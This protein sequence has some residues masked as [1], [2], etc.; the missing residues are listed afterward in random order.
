MF[1]KN[2]LFA[3]VV[4]VWLTIATKAGITWAGTYTE[5]SVTFI[6]K[7]PVLKWKIDTSSSAYGTYNDTLATTG[8]GVLDI[9]A[10]YGEIPADDMKAM[11]AA[12]FLEGAL[13]AER[14]YQN[15][16]NMHAFYF[17]GE[18]Q[19]L[20]P[21]V[22][23][24]FDEQE[25][26]TR[27]MIAKN[28]NDQFWRSIALIV[29]QL[30]GLVD[31]YSNNPY[32]NKSLERFAFQMLNSVGDL[33]DLRHALSPS[34]RPDWSKMNPVE[35][36]SYFMRHGH[37]SALIK[38]LGAYEN[39][40]M[41]HSSWFV[42]ASTSRIYKH[43]NFNLKSV[44]VASKQMS[45]SSYPGFLESLDDFYLLGN[46]LVMLQTTLN[47]FNNSLYDY[48]V[49]QS[50]LAW[51]RV[52]AA[53]MLAHN[54]KEWS[55]ILAKYNSGTYNN[56]YMIIDLNLIHLNESI[57]DNALWVVEQMPT[58]VKSGDQSPILRA[59]YFPSYNVPFYEEVFNISG[60]PEM[61]AKYGTDYS[62]QLAP[63]AKIFRRDQG[64]VKSFQD[65]KHLMRYNDYLHD[66]YSQMDPCK[67]ICCRG[68]LYKENPSADGC[69]DTKLS[70]YHMARK[71]QSEAISGPTLGTGLPPFEWTPKFPDMHVGLPQIYNFSFLT[72]EPQL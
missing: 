67:A 2:L 9:K 29:A 39:I 21:K 8:W 49:P 18:K 1:V 70:D 55:Q 14:I 11:Y 57:D 68:D 17:G 50:L 33:I 12:G 25:T 20:E 24:F 27:S 69:Y 53:N 41:S 10:G 16:L 4:V 47:V 45:F 43:Y 23:K 64:K 40:F 31:G 62:Y 65:M 56:E 72:M 48:V 28:P 52:R 26:W 63:R 30:D 13:T 36:Q 58:M 34:T 15:Y 35:F 61:V 5:G 51:Y 60:Y 32:Q 71:L 59:G 37:C 6:G 46:G 44:D 3:V 22:K 66:E 54:G 42:Y 38:V 19:S 7:T